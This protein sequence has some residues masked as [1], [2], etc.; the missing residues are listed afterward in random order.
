M[1][2]VALNIQHTICDLGGRKERIGI[3]LNNFLLHDKT[4]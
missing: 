4:Y 2:V 1:V 3:V